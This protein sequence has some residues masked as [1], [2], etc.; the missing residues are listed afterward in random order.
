MS[1]DKI[2]RNL[3]RQRAAAKGIFSIA[4]LSRRVGCSRPAIYFAIEKPTR[5][6]LVHSRIVKLIGNIHD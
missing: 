5:Y 2:N 3:L 1:L 6:P 4:E